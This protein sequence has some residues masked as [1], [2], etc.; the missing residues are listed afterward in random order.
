MLV[1][2]HWKLPFFIEKH[3]VS[4]DVPIDEIIFQMFFVDFELPYHIRKF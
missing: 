1:C 2:Y 4:V 3:E